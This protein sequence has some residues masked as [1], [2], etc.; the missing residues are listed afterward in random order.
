LEGGFFG[1]IADGGEKF[2]PLN[3]PEDFKKKGLKVRIRG[4]VKKVMSISMWGK[5][6]KILDIEPD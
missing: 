1:L 5:P 2:L 3:L 6:L 4:E